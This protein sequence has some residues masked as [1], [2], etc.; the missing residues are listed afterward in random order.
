MNAKKSVSKK[1]KT[2][3]AKKTVAKKKVAVKKKVTSKKKVVSKKAIARKAPVKAA[4][5]ANVKAIAARQTKTQII[6]DLAEEC[7]LEKKQVASVFS[8]LGRKIEAHVKPRGSGEFTIP[9][10]G[11]KVS[12]VIKPRT[13]ARMGRNPATG[14]AIKIAA[15][16]ARKVIRL[17]AFKSLKLKI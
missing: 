10:T 17:T 15:K 5:P 8:A 6:A 11:I 16:P 1:K 4:A 13:K 7:G 2:A 12:R 3:T 14:E 9:E